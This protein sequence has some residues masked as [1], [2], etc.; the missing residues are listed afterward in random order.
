MDLSNFNLGDGVVATLVTTALGGVAVWVRKIF[1]KNKGKLTLAIKLGT[2]V[3]ETSEKVIETIKL[4]DKVVEDN[5][6]NKAEIKEVSVQLVDL[7][8]DLKE[9]VLAWKELVKKEEK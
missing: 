5:V 1:T 7:R 8:K 6:I 2:E 9:V 4:L 3:V